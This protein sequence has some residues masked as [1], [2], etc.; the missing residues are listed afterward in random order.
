MGTQGT[1]R[2]R[3]TKKERTTA[4]DDA[5]DLIAREAEARLAAKRAARAEAREIRMKELE[6]QQKEIFQVQKKY[7][8]LNP[9]PDDVADR[10]W[11]DIEQWMEDSERYSRSSRMRTLSD[12]DER[13]SVGSRSSVRSS[14]SHKKSKKKK[15]HKHKD[16]D[17]NGYDD[18][19][20]DDYSVLSSRSSRLSEDSRLSHASRLDLQPASY[21]SSD[22]YG[23][24][25]LSSSRHAGSTLNGYQLY[26]ST[27][28]FS[29]QLCYGSSLYD[30]GLGSRRVTGSSSHPLEYTNYVSSSS[31][32]SSRASSARAS[33]VENCGSVASFLRSTAS[34]GVLPRDLDD[35][36]IPDF[37]DVDDK[38]YLEKGSRA[39]SALTAATLSSVGG[40]SSRRGS[41]ETA[42]TV[43]ADTSIREIKEAL[44]EVE[45]K[46]RKA[47]V[48]NAQLDNEKTNLI[49]QVDT[50]K[51]S[52]MELEELLSESRR[53]FEEKVK[54]CEREKYGHSVLQFQFNELKETL[55][56]SEELLNKH[57]IVL[58]PDLTVNGDIGEAEVDGLPSGDAAPTPAQVSQT[59]PVEGKSMLGNAEENQ[60]R[61]SIKEEVQQEQHQESWTE[62]SKQN[63]LSSDALCSLAGVSSLKTSSET[64]STK[65]ES[66]NQQITSPTDANTEESKDLNI[67]PVREAKDKIICSPELE[68]IVRAEENIPEKE[69]LGSDLKEI[70]NPYVEEEN[71]SAD[72]TEAVQ[73]Q[74]DRKEAVEESDLKNKLMDHQQ[75]AKG[76]LNE[77]APAPSNAE[78]QQEMENVCEEENSETEELASK[79]LSK[80]QDAT[81]SGKK[82]KRK[83]RG[84]K[85]GSTQ[86]DKSQQKDEVQKEDKARIDVELDK[87]GNGSTKQCKVDSANKGLKDQK[88]GQSKTEQTAETQQATEPKMDHTDQTLE[89]RT[90]EGTEEVSLTETQAHTHSPQETRTRPLKNEQDDK[91]LAESKGIDRVQ[92]AVRD[93]CPETISTHDFC[94][95][96]EASS[97]NQAG[98]EQQEQEREGL[99]EAETVDSTG[100]KD[101]ETTMTNDQS[102]KPETVEEVEVA[103]ATET[104]VHAERTVI[105]PCGV[106]KDEQDEEQNVKR[107]TVETLEDSLSMSSLFVSSEMIGS[108]ASPDKESPSS[109]NTCNNGEAEPGRAEIKPACITSNTETKPVTNSTESTDRKC[110]DPSS[111]DAPADELEFT[112]SQTVGLE[113][114]ELPLESSVAISDSARECEEAAETVKE[115]EMKIEQEWCLYSHDDRNPE[116]EDRM[117]KRPEDAA[118]HRCNAEEEEEAVAEIES[119][120]ASDESNVWSSPETDGLIAA[121][122]TDSP[123][124]EAHLEQ[125]SSLVIE[126][127]Q[128]NCRN[129]GDC[130]TTWPLNELLH[131]TDS[132]QPIEQDGDGGCC[133]DE[134]GQ[135]FDFDDMDVETAV[136]SHVSRDLDQEEAEDAVEVVAD[137]SHSVVSVSGRS[138]SEPDE[139]TQEKPVKARD[140]KH[141][142]EVGPQE[143]NLHDLTEGITNSLPQETKPEKK[144][145]VADEEG[146]VIN[147][148]N[149]QNM[150]QAASVSADEASDA[151]RHEMQKD[152]LVLPKSDDQGEVSRELL[153]AGKDGKKSSKK[154]KGKSKE[155]CKM[156]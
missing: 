38:E 133:E 115:Q 12:D 62:E 27:T 103:A 134:E 15:K 113:G 81:T 18:D 66:K 7:Y 109:L 14:S 23:L 72:D 1:G 135:S 141:E 104:S 25:G 149:A 3:S 105:T 112:H 28:Q 13:M 57:G 68:E 155:E 89:T 35:V 78:S 6:R 143:K 11:G 146:K 17:R 30:D 43:D 33:P 114:S 156:S 95:S 50:L 34:S 79:T 132:S 122:P 144:E 147:D 47:M 59:S 48:S 148:V 118:C 150:K 54:E 100:C 98:N 5:L 29:Q 82:K 51:D 86:E 152:A 88:L 16:R 125:E 120:T 99:T 46:Y 139:N 92:S 108:G 64:P 124:E 73:A 75:N 31:R 96:P 20:D 97:I 58:G 42:G 67:G 111:G 2:K 126:S 119:Q 142:A 19:D 80:S 107:D 85:K 128:K 69:T 101:D 74:E 123:R 49:Y 10:K 106:S 130:E 55:K 40:T 45:E 151:I 36:T 32:A 22:L 41:G 77:S 154:G 76:S 83:R 56:Q 131:S 70:N 121:N 84:K 24:N 138:Y 94:E 140:E 44:A 71:K 65:S 4:E 137:E 60:L 153:Q 116:I 37:S 110:R 93:Q 127:Q 136:A 8:D 87:G 117:E 90:L 21:A 61:S 63:N 39:A 129:D 26:R 53:E 91:E 145:N 102:L 52:L 9:K